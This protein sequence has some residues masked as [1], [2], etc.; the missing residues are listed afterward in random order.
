M[1][2]N[3]TVTSIAGAL[4][5]LGTTTALIACGGGDK[6]PVNANEVKSAEPTKASESHCGADHKE[7]KGDAKC[8]AKDPGGAAGAATSAATSA[9]SAA[10]TTPPATTA[11]ATP[12]SATPAGSAKPA[13]GTPGKGSTKAGGQASC[14][15]GTCSAKK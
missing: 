5:V 13:G 7:H 15:A 3:L 9:A 12:G 1:R 11:P 6:P 8:A 14:G 2:P 10:P 4:A